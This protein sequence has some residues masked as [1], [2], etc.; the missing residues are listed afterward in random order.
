M[1]NTVYTEVVTLCTTSLK[2]GTITTS[3]F[4]LSTDLQLLGKFVPF[5]FEIRD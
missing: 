3:I 5:M 1:K 4:F 2:I